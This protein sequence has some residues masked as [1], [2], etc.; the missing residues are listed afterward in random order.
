M[1]CSLI[2]YVLLINTI[3]FIKTG[4]LISLKSIL[5]GQ[6]VFLGS[7]FNMVRMKLW[8]PWVL[9]ALTYGIALVITVKE[10][11]FLKNENN[12]EKFN[13]NIFIFILAI[14]GIGVFSYYQGRSHNEC[15][16]AVLYPGIMLLG[17]FLDYILENFSKCTKFEKIC[18]CITF[19][20][21]ITI[22]VN[23][24]SLTFYSFLYEKRNT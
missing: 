4:Q 9:I 24:S 1:I 15:F 23:F 12:S 16:K 13:K 17:I 22:L 11:K 20:I 8:H 7:G 6:N 21:I 14:L 5:F 2:L 10:L 19:S 3:T 18:E